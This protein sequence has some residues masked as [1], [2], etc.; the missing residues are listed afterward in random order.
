MTRSWWMAALLASLAL[1]SACAGGPRPAAEAG[2]SQWV[3][4]SDEPE[5][6]KRARIRLELAAGYFDKGQTTVALDEVKQAL[7]ADPTYAAA[8]NLRGLVFMRLNEPQLAESSFREALRLAP[9]DGDSWHNL[10][11]FYCQRERYAD[12][13]QAFEN[14]LKTP[15]YAASPRT[16]LA[17]GVCQARA[18]QGEAAE[19]S[20]M[21]SFDLDPVNPITAYNLGL[22]LH[23]RGESEKAR[24]YIR[25]LNNSDL[26]NAESLW[27]GVKIENRLQNPVAA[28]QLGEQLRRRF[29]D[30]REANALE[31]GAFHE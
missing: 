26:A 14:A 16:L 15:N 23:Q 8:Y 31:R 4:E 21:R 13:V 22:M 7:L 9:N 18:G 29:P 2:S 27:L 12:A 19:R 5:V 30:S 1:L 10:G 25:R 28:G 11:W 3:T 20:L 24:F 17:M 6:R